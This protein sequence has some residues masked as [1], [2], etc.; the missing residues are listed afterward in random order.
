MLFQHNPTIRSC[1]K[2]VIH[3]FGNN[4]EKKILLANKRNCKIRIRLRKMLQPLV[5]IF[6]SIL[7]RFRR[8]NFKR[9]LNSICP[10][11]KSLLSRNSLY[12]RKGQHIAVNSRSK[13]QLQ[14]NQLKPNELQSKSNE[15]QS[16]QSKSN[17]TNQSPQPQPF[18]KQSTHVE[19]SQSILS[20]SSMERILLSQLVSSHTPVYNVSLFLFVVLKRILPRKLLGSRHNWN[21]FF[22]GKTLF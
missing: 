1:R 8:L 5:L 14:S 21:V 12:K 7:K 22:K 20:E 13:K 10:I 6:K 2:L 16:N 11:E 19:Q 4:K 17:Q 15:L 9:L 18:A 3:L